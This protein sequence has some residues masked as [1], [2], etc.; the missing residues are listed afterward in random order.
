MGVNEKIF[1]EYYVGRRGMYHNKN[2]VITSTYYDFIEYQDFG[3]N[4]DE[5][6]ITIYYEDGSK[7]Y[8]SLKGNQIKRNLRLY[9]D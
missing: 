1:S 6:T 8:T 7:M 3:F 2:V 5:F 9:E 4:F